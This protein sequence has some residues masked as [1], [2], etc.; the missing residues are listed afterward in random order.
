MNV[1]ES[2]PTFSAPR[3]TLRPVRAEDAP[4]LLAVYSDPDAQPLFNADNCTS[5]FRYTT[6]PEMEACM[7]MWLWSYEHGWFVRWV[8]LEGDTPVGTVEMFRRDNG[9]DGRGSGVLRIDM[10]SRCETADVLGELLEAI[11]PSM[12][13][14]FGCGTVLTKAPAFARERLSALK[15][16]G[17]TPAAPLIAHDGRPLG[18]YWAHRA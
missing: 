7:N 2:C 11:L 14:L 6:L 4:G 12:H 17:F 8:I 9:D 5:D 10:L 1:Y 15:T 16:H 18:D 3:F 13:E